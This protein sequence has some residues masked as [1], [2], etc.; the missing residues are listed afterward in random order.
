MDY[1]LTN[2]EGFNLI[3]G[4]G[5]TIDVYNSLEKLKPIIVPL[6]EQ[7]L[8]FEALEDTDFSFVFEGDPKGGYVDSSM[9]ESLSYSLDNGNTWV[10]YETPNDVTGGVAFTTPTVH[11]WDRILWKGIGTSNQEAPNETKYC[12]FA[13]TGRF[14]ISGNIMSLLYGDN[15][16]QQ[17]N[18]T[19]E[20]SGAFASLFFRSK[21]VSA[22][23]LILPA[24]VADYC[25]NNMFSYCTNLTTT[26]ELPATTLANNCYKGMFRNCTRLL[27]PPELTATTLANSCYREIFSMCQNMLCAPELPATTMSNNC[28]EGMFSH[29][30]RLIKAPELPATTL[31][32]GCYVN[33]FNNCTS[34][35]YIKAMFTTTPSNT[36]TRDWVYGVAANGTFTKNSAATWNVTGS[37]GVPS[38]WT[39]QTANS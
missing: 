39:V 16:K 11:R 18:L 2:T 36:Y 37:N 25:Y 22:E 33:M 20:N 32:S 27:T 29:C 17:T 3:R 31:A 26:P 5:N 4:G 23:N 19:N 28:Y 24:N 8:T 21:V 1:K 14:S 34:L 38:G 7:Y 10:T 6:K 13:S 30:I 35:N 12:R 15:F 9:R